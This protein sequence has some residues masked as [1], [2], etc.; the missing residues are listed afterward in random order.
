MFGSGLLYLNPNAGNL[1][2]NPTPVKPFTIQDVKVGLK[3]KIEA[4]RGQN[5][6]PD[7][8]ATGD[9]DGTFEFSM[10]RRDF[11][12]LNQ[13]FNADT[14]TAGGN[15]VYPNFSVTA[16]TTVTIVP[17]ASGAFVEDLGVT[18]AASGKEFQKLTT[19]PAVGQYECN[20]S[21]GV[22]TFAAGDAGVTVLISYLYSQTTA[23]G[24]TYQVNN[25]IQGYGPAFEAFLLDTYQPVMSSGIP[26]Y[27]TIRLYAAKISDV[28]ID[29]KRGGY[30]MVSLKGSYFASP[31]GR[32]ID[33]YSNV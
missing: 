14:T 19:A 2:T 30:G 18:Y 9:K 11:F 23:G 24:T 17:P 6:F 25:Q 21:T 15:A 12:L 5:Q 4:L 16:A 8:T 27:S 22:Y 1:A 20:N 13:I 32:V 31:S 7:D 3:G 29:N 26:V 10:G 28:E 33:F